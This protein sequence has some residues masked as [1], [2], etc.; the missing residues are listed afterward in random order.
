MTYWRQYM[1]YVVTC[2]GVCV[3]CVFIGLSADTPAMTKHFWHRTIPLPNPRPEYTE[4]PPFPDKCNYLDGFNEWNQY[5][6]WLNKKLGLSVDTKFETTLKILETS[7]MRS[8]MCTVPRAAQVV[9]DYQ[10]NTTFS[11][12]RYAN[13]NYVRVILTEYYKG[14]M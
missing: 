5:Q 8:Q 11:V 1:A 2:M 14:E 9:K 13:V 6:V 7:P 4:S 10:Y 3:F 12:Q